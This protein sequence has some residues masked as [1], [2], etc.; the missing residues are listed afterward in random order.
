M[1]NVA[2]SRITVLFIRKAESFLS[3]SAML[4]PGGCVIRTLEPHF[5]LEKLLS[6]RIS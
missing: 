1:G 3:L 4:V 2:F 6:F 5:I